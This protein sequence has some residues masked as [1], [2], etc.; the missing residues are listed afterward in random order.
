MNRQIKEIKKTK[1]N[2]RRLSRN[3]EKL[4]Y[5]NSKFRIKLLFRRFL[6]CNIFNKGYLFI[7]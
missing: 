7:L 2:N 5:F 4:L 1:L 3:I 6:N